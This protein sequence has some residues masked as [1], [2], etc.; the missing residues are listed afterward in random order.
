LD[1]SRSR[2]LNHDVFVRDDAE[3]SAYDLEQLP[4]GEQELWAGRPPVALVAGGERLVDER[5]ARSHD[6]QQ[7]R[8]DRTVQVVRHDHGGEASMREREGTPLLEIDFDRLEPR[9]VEEVVDA[10][11]FAIDGN[12]TVT[13]SQ[14]QPGV[15]AAAACHVEHG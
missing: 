9:L 13:A 15:P 7:I 6:R 10:C 8:K 11:E 5:A 4:G 12:D 2:F 3:L 1:G 14:E